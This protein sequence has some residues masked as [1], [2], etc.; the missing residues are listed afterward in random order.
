M[1]MRYTMQEMV[2]LAK[3]ADQKLEQFVHTAAILDEHR[4]NLESQR[5]SSDEEKTQIDDAL[6]AMNGAVTADT[7]RCVI[8]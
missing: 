1:A 3:K 4:E 6:N 5:R 8:A 2:D 7:Y